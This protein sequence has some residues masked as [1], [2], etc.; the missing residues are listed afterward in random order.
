M[1]ILPHF[2]FDASRQHV[3]LT[4]QSIGEAAYSTAN[5]SSNYIKLCLTLRKLVLGAQGKDFECSRAKQATA[6]SASIKLGIF[7]NSYFAQHLLFIAPMAVPFH[8]SKQRR[9]QDWLHVRHAQH[10][11]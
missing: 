1:H 11:I 7:G 2:G 8:K 4:C 3:S 5:F 10:A 6:M 9:R